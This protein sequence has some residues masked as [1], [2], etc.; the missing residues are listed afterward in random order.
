M[1]SFDTFSTYLGII[2]FLLTILAPIAVG[3]SWWLRRATGGRFGAERGAQKSS[4]ARLRSAPVESIMGNYPERMGAGVLDLQAMAE[5]AGDEKD[6]ALTENL[7]AAVAQLFREEVAKR[8]RESYPPSSGARNILI[9]FVIL[10]VVFGALNI[11]HYWGAVKSRGDLMLWGFG[12]FVSMIGG[13]FVQVL[14]ANYQSGKRLFAVE[15]SELL[16]PALFSL[17]VF[18]PVWALT[19]AGSQTLFS[20]YAAFLNG[21]FWRAIVSAARV[22]TGT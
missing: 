6:L 17:V 13:M 4:D 18:C 8:E 3:F 7:R 20:Y 21:Y 19:A 14:S 9:A 5:T 12:L 22:P 16:F 2:S 1:M 10:V 11:F 15:G